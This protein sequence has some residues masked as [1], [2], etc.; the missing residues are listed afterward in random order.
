MN[1]KPIESKWKMKIAIKIIITK[2]IN[3][4][5]KQNKKNMIILHNR[6]YNKIKKSNIL[7][8]KLKFKKIIIIKLSKNNKFLKIKINN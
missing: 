1:L 2:M 7:N 3:K 4:I 5:N 6:C 8:Q